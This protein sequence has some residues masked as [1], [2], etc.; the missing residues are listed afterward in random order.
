MRRRTA[1]GNR[2]GLSIV[3]G[4]LVLAGLAA[5]ARGRGWFPR[6]LGNPDAPIIDQATQAF[7]ARQGWFWPVLAVIMV[8]IALLALRWL[9]VQTRTGAVGTLRLEP[10]PAQGAIRLPARAVTG[11]LAD[12][13]A[14]SPSLRRPR[15]RLTG[16]PTRPRLHLTAGVDPAADPGAVRDRLHQVVD[17]SRQ[18][19]ESPELPTTIRLGR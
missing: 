14:A 15:A 17:R 8:G 19:L 18:T 12:D 9:L 2:I 4:L 7:P 11:A 16:S 5:L 1:R 13:L 10:D 6:L 3:G